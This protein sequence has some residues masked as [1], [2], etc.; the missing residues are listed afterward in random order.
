V[1]QVVADDADQ[2]SNQVGVR[3]GIVEHPFGPRRHVAGIRSSKRAAALRVPSTI[4]TPREILVDGVT[5]KTHFS[6][7]GATQAAA[8]AVQ[9]IR[10]RHLSPAVYVR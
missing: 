4:A 3:L 6:Q 1:P 9:G 8:P 5:D 2:R 10:V 7:Y